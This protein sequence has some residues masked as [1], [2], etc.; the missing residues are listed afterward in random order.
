MTKKKLEMIM[1]EEYESEFLDL[2]NQTETELHE[3]EQQYS[4]L[5]KIYNQYL[6]DKQR[7]I[8]KCTKDGILI[9]YIKTKHEQMGF[10]I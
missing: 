7:F 9:N 5:I 2:I 10:K 8:I 3:V 6:K 4:T 1:K